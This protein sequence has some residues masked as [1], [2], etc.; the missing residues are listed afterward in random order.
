MAIL[1]LILSPNPILKMKSTSVEVVDKELQKFLDDLLETMYYEEGAGLAA[2]QVG[3]LKRIFVLDTGKNDEKESKD[4]H[5]YINPEIIYC[6]E[7]KSVINEGCLSFPGPRA[8]ISRSDVVRIR[9]MDYDGNTQETE[10][11][12]YKARGFLHENDHLDGITMPDHLAPMK[13]DMFNRQ[14]KKYIRNLDQ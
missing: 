3:L 13:R 9:Y 11:S 1:P 7:E 5:F 10:A 2:V 14:V 12:G 6:S 4:P 8:M